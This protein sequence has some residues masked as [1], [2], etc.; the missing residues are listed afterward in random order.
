MLLAA[1]TG[2]IDSCS[3]EMASTVQPSRNCARKK[4][5]DKLCSCVD[6]KSRMLQSF[7]SDSYHQMENKRFS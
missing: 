7:L 5:Q 4:R 1:R 2:L 3:R 6:R